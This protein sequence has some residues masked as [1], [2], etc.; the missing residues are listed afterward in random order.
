M[1]V[2]VV[3]MAVAAVVV[4]FNAC[5]VCC[6]RGTAVVSVY[7][8]LGVY[9]TLVWVLLVCVTCLVC[10]QAGGV[11]A[12]RGGGRH[13]CVC[14]CSRAPSTATVATAVL[15]HCKCFL[16]VP[17]GSGTDD[18]CAAGSGDDAYCVAGVCLSPFG[19]YCCCSCC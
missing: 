5:C 17:V 14:V 1:L 18:Y 10:V 13:V 4:F 3:V 16:A 12:G 6:C 2:V 11:Q 7:D 8:M 9:C 19:L 15:E